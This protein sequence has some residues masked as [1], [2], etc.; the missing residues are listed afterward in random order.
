[1][2]RAQK[3]WNH[4]WFRDVIPLADLLSL[5]SIDRGGSS[6]YKKKQMKNVKLQQ[7]SGAGRIW[8]G[9]IFISAEVQKVINVC[10]RV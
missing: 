4:A 10:K 1:M 2:K 7:C 8:G 9:S 5:F 6:V 3:S